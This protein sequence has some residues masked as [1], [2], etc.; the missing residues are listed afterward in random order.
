MI[1]MKNHHFVLPN[2]FCEK[3]NFLTFLFSR[4]IATAS[5]TFV[6]CLPLCA[7]YVLEEYSQDY[8]ML[9]ANMLVANQLVQN[10]SFSWEV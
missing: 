8:V 4:D 9:I 7:S 10:V 3:D 1:I 5:S 6:C 2:N